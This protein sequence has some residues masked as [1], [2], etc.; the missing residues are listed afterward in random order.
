MKCIENGCNND[1]RNERSS[2]CQECF[3]KYFKKEES[4]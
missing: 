4:A 1:V 3:D 2:L